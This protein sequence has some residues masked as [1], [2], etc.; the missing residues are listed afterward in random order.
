[1]SVAPRILG[2]PLT[3]TVLG[4]V[5]LAAWHPPVAPAP[6]GSFRDDSI[7][8]TRLN[9]HLYV[10]EGAIDVVVA[11]V[12]PDGLLLVDGG[13]PETASMVRAALRR[14]GRERPDLMITT[15]YHHGFA[16]AAL[17]EG[18]TIVAHRNARNRMRHPN[19]MAGRIV[20]PFDSAG[21]PVVTFDDSLTIHF[22]GE[23]IDLIHFPRGHTDGD[24]VAFFRG[25]N[26][27]ATG[28]LAVPHLPWTDYDAGGEFADLLASL[29]RLLA[30]VPRDAVI[31]PGH[32]RPMRYDDVV[33]LHA[34]LSELSTWVRR[35]I[36]RGARVQ[37]LVAEGVPPSVRSWMGGVP[38]EL[39]IESAY[40]AQPAARN[41]RAR[42][43]AYLNGRWFEGGGFVAR[44]MYAVAGVLSTPRPPQVDTVIDLSGGWVVPPFGEAH[45]HALG[46]PRTVAEQSRALLRAGVFY[47]IVQDAAADVGLA[48]RRQ[49]NGPGSV[50]VVY[51]QGVITPSWGVI[52]EFYAAL[53]RAGHFG[54][55][56]APERLRDS[57]YFVV[58][59]TVDLARLWPRIRAANRDHV[60]VIV[61]FSDE[62]ERRRGNPRF[63]AEPGRFSAR[64]GVTAPVLRALVSRAH[65]AR[66][67]VSAHVE[68]AADFRLAVDAGVDVIA[69]LPAAWQVGPETG[70]EG[71]DNTPWLLTDDD[72]QRA[73]SRR[74][75]VVT[76]IAAAADLPRLPRLQ[77]IH[78]H[79]LAVLAQAGAR[80]AFGSDGAPGATVDEALAIAGLGVF[81]TLTILQ[82]LAQATPRAI[83]PGRRIGFL[84]DGFEA[85][86]LV[87]PSNPLTSL[88]AIRSVRLAV[89]QGQVVGR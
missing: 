68:T 87:L 13:Y 59:D 23:E 74:V 84:R 4:L 67:R 56:V 42:T 51:T 18:A 21:W 64:P 76:T 8:V 66:L 49:V 15:H 37:D 78:R 45:T 81:D 38:V 72:A 73:A 57:L 77:A 43:V 22:N 85:S 10:L 69:H 19:L 55:G 2:S 6:L 24:V 58:D 25:S 28:D 29:D 5:F 75:L 65:T 27:V 46:D 17:S 1:M 71:D 32:D 30:L 83:F 88:E 60:K 14:L 7:T 35:G 16:N 26:V 11:S 82:L 89:K 31:V 86:F 34:A 40:L 62:I 52:P 61:A 70:Y 33:G 80:L 63:G 20:Q 47:T 54:P 48:V 39:V 44:P 12:G 53:A 50:D 79:N 41:P 36:A 9:D 3:F